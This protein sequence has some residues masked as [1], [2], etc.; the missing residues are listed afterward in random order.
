MNLEIEIP[1]QALFIDVLHDDEAEDR[2]AYQQEIVAQLG[3]L[4]TDA[5]HIEGYAALW[6]QKDKQG[7]TFRRGAFAESLKLSSGA[8]GVLMHHQHVERWPIGK[9]SRITEDERGL[10]CRGA[11]IPRLC[12]PEVLNEVQAPVQPLRGLSPGFYPRVGRAFLRPSEI[13]KVWLTEISIGRNPVLTEA[14]FHVLNR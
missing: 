2:F 8:Y 12:S 7:D 5:I 10:R 9:W 4:P 11:I 13:R 14:S 3:S 1:L 6:G